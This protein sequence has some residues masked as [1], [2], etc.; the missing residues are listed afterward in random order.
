V[1]PA[2]E[3]AG[4]PGASFHTGVAHLALALNTAV[5]PFGLAGTENVMPPDPSA[6]GG[7][8]IAGVPVSIHRGPLAI[9]F[10]ER[11][12]MRPDE[13]PESFTARVQEVCYSLTRQAEH[14]LSGERSHLSVSAGDHARSFR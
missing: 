8:L 7:R 5:V 6:F 12:R 2:D 3:R 4:H 11:Q 13:S 10:G 9:A 1:R 14:A